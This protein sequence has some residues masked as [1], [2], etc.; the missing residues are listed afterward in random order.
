MPNLNQFEK[1]G[2]YIIVNNTK[3]Y[4]TGKTQNGYSEVVTGDGQVGWVYS[5]LLK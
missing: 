2:T 1:R 3:L 5:S 4:G